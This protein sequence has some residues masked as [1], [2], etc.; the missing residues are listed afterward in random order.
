VWHA[1]ASY[2]VSMRPVPP[3]HWSSSVRRQIERELKR[4]L[5]GVG[6]GPRRWEKGSERGRH[7]LHVRRS[8]SDAEIAELVDG[9]PATARGGDFGGVYACRFVAP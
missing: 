1:S 8:L 6:A 2:H 9:P 3:D 5:A 4:L 7:V